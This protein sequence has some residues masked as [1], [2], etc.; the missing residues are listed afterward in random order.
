MAADA[1]RA[2]RELHQRAAQADAIAR[3]ARDARDA[4]IRS[5]ISS[6]ATQRSIAEALG[7]SAGMVA[8]IALGGRA[9]NRRRTDPSNATSPT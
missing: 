8:R 3:E 6:G 1:L 9:P 4:L 7:I 5:E 2:A